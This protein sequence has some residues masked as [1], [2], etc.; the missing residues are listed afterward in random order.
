MNSIGHLLLF[1]LSDMHC[2]LPLA[3]IERILRVV[4]INPIPKAPEILIGLINVQGRIIPVLNL[5]RQFRLPASEVTLN[6]QLII[7]RSTNG[8]AALLVDNVIGV[9][10]Y[11]EQEIIGGDELF[12]GIESLEG[13]AKLKDGIIYIYHLDSL[14]SVEHATEIASFAA[15]DIQP[16]G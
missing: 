16:S 11:S 10:E 5:R 12:P 8:S 3:E 13:V 14:F 1:T 6:D 2:A 4:E 9:R 7:A 15:S